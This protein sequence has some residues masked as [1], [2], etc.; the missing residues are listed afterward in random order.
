VP[1]L[2]RFA[3]GDDQLIEIDRFREVVDGAVAH[4][5]DRTADVGKGRD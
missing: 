3:D 4:R 5:R 2:D 1:A